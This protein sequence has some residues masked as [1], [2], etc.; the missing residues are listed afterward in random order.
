MLFVISEN[1]YKISVYV[2]VFEAYSRGVTYEISCAYDCF[3]S[4]IFNY[5]IALKF[6]IEIFQYD[7]T[8][9]LLE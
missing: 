2:K 7:C 5:I 4:I 1:V 3:L 8:E 9:S 6:F